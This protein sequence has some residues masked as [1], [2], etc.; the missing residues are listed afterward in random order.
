[1]IS[2]YILSCRNQKTITTKDGRKMV[3]PCGYC[4]DC[5][6]KRA[7][8]ANAL[9]Q[10]AASSH[11]FVIKIDLTYDEVCVPKMLLK[12][13]VTK[14]H[15]KYIQCID[16]TKRP[17]KTKGKHGDYTKRFKTYGKVI[18][19]INSTF[20]NPLFQEFY[21]KSEA[22]PPR[23]SPRFKTFRPLPR[24]TLRYSCFKDCQ[25]FLKR[26]RFYL[27]RETDSVFSYYFVSEY[28]P[29]TFRPHFHGVLFTS[30]PR[31][32]QAVKKCVS[33]AWKYGD[34][35]CELA[36]NK[37]GS[38]S[39]VSSYINSFSHLPVFLR[40]EN[41]KPRSSHSFHLGEI[42]AKF[43]RDYIYRDASRAFGKNSVPIGSG[44]YKYYPSSTNINTLFPRCYDY[45]NKHISELYKL[46]TIYP[47]LSR[48]YKTEQCS[49][50]VD[51]LMR[52]QVGFLSQ[53]ESYIVKSFLH[54]L[55]VTP[56]YYVEDSNGTI[57][58]ILPSHEFDLSASKEKWLCLSSPE[59]YDSI[60]GQD[61]LTLA[62]RDLDDYTLR[63]WH[64]IYSAVRLSKYVHEFCCE[65]ISFDE[66]FEMLVAF[67]KRLPL[68][69]LGQFYQMQ[70]EYIQYTN[71][72]ECDVFY[73][74]QE[75]NPEF[76]YT[77]CYQQNLF[78]QES[79]KDRDLQYAKRVKHKELND[80]NKIFC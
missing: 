49:T 36:N 71:D 72:K 19:S 24:Y 63:L 70:E 52:Y 59:Y 18:H 45:G 69:R 11:P 46:Y 47:K 22:T 20:D 56:H 62:P 50:I 51:N 21:E 32:V 29:Q 61:P 10:S 80:A 17:L 26:L 64:R 31:L 12:E 9:C 4:P 38:T 54:N 41:V 79:L 35:V 33:K 2:K 60:I 13:V 34:Y 55:H 68:T 40:G 7:N 78:L 39:Y 15:R 3:V 76:D 75:T 65:R 37:G 8:H 58:P 42:N 1:M 16:I 66:W 25:D 67:H 74:V 53:Q 6:T 73:P 5:A 44:V 43:V 30:D 28:G 23:D 27:T 57:R 48:I 77:T 14:D